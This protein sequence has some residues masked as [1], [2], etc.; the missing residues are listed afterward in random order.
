MPGGTSGTPLGYIT[1]A[2]FTTRKSLRRKLANRIKKDGVKVGIAT[3]DTSV[4]P[5]VIQLTNLLVD[6]NGLKSNIKWGSGRFKE[7]SIYRLDTGEETLVAN[8]D[9]QQ[10]TILPDHNWLAA[11]TSG[12]TEYEIHT[13]GLTVADLH[14]SLDYAT[15]AAKTDRWM[16]LPGIVD[17]VTSGVWASSVV[18]PSTVLEDDGYYSERAQGNGYLYQSA[19]VQPGTTYSIYATARVVTGTASIVIWDLTNNQALTWQGDTIL[20][21]PTWMMLTGAVIIPPTCSQVQMRLISTSETFWRDVGLRRNGMPIYIPKYITDPQNQIL[22][23]S[24]RTLSAINGSAAYGDSSAIA[25]PRPQ[26]NLLPDPGVGVSRIYIHVAFPYGPLVYDS[27][28]VPKD[29]EEW[30]LAGATYHALK[31]LVSVPTV[32]TDPY[33]G[34]AAREKVVWNNKN[35]AKQPL[36]RFGRPTYE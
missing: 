16:V 28:G 18:T 8:Y 30:I 17:E 33:A 34:I 35:A 23:P 4:T 6:A 2:N 20:T 14:E 21:G 31:K 12:V 26:G 29:V 24:L 9:A 22:G 1:P 5:N 10:G 27:D 25:V 36:M 13:H 19:S 7:S 11:P 15:L 3:N 32:S